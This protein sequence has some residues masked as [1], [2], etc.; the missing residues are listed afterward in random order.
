MPDPGTRHPIQPLRCN[1]ISPGAAPPGGIEGPLVYVGS[2]EWPR[3]NGKTIQGAVVLME[4]E[5]GRNWLNAANIGARA[6]IYVDRGDSPRF[7]YE[8]KYELSPM[9]M[10]RF[11][12]ALSEARALLGA[13][14][15]APDGLVSSRVR[16]HSNVTWRSVEAKNIYAFQPGSDPELGEELLIVEA[17]YDSSALVF[18]KSPGADE[19][20]SAGVLLETARALKRRP[21]KRSVLLVAAAGHGQTLAGA[22]EMI[23]SVQAKAKFFR[24]MKKRLKKTMAEAGEIVDHISRMGADPFDGETPHHILYKMLNDQ[25]K[26]EVDVLS[27]KLMRLRMEEE[28]GAEPSNLRELAQR[29]R[30]LRTLGWR[31][32]YT[33]LSPAERRELS[34]LIPLAAARR[35]AILRDAKLELAHLKSAKKFRTLVREK[36]IAGV[37]SLHLSSHGDG[38]GAFN[39]GFLYN[40]KPTIRRVGAYSVLDEVLRQSAEALARTRDPGAGPGVPLHDTLRPSKRK[41]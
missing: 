25:I 12:L 16:L 29:R 17:F 32:E 36:E 38:V 22:R 34:R 2:G 11:R 40:L 9:D 5:S 14:E 37:A 41:T 39:R 20:I 30:L 6:V 21:P 28:G 8:D 18:G 13:F 3:F 35:K 27:R 19:A 33:D 23:W 7:N 1:A 31:T 24:N 4:L 15:T 10:P 26:T